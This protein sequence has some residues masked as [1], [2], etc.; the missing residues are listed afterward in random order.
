M[1]RAGGDRKR[2]ESSP[3]NLQE[4]QLHDLR[5]EPEPLDNEQSGQHARTQLPEPL[6]C[7]RSIFDSLAL[8]LS[9]TQG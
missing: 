6:H 5:L 4:H 8:L 1:Q 2:P 7:Q 3:L 9:L